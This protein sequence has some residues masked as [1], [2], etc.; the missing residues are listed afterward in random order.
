MHIKLL[1]SII[2]ASGDGFTLIEILMAMAVA[3]I[4]LF[5]LA[6]LQCT[7]IKGNALSSRHTQ[8]T[9]L[10]QNILERLK[11]GHMVKEGAFGLR[12]RPLSKS[13]VVQDAGVFTGVTEGGDAGGPFNVQWQVATHT[14]WSRLIRVTVSWESVLGQTRYLSLVSSSFGNGN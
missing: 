14:E 5:S 8:A 7:A 13:W 11:N 9:F 4:G 6:H 12:K 3:A 2:D 1:D 10:A